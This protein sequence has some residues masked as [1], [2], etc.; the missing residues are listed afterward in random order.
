MVVPLLNNFLLSVETNPELLKFCFRSVIGPENSR[1]PPQ[2]TDAK[3][4]P[5]MIWSLP[6]RF[7]AFS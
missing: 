2:P 3:L 4:K 7:L 6:L 5:I 1:P